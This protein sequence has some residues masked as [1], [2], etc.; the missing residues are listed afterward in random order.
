MK[1]KD[2]GWFKYSF[3]ESS[4]IFD[5]W[6]STFFLTS[7]F[8]DFL[9]KRLW[10]I[11][12][13]SFFGSI[14]NRENKG[15]WNTLFLGGGDGG[16]KFDLCEFPRKCSKMNRCLQSESTIEAL[17]LKYDPLHLEF[18]LCFFFASNYNDISW[19]YLEPSN[20]VFH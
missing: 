11:K 10:A 14:V 4:W 19:L 17:K 16:H 2:L 8:C 12:T 18:Q 15:F 20:T 3:S 1:D 13:F 6:C 7:E 9:Y 5:T